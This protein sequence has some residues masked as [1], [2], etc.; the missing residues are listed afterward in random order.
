MATS[1]NF[2][3]GNEWDNFDFDEKEEEQFD[4]KEAEQDSGFDELM[5]DVQKSILEESKNVNT[6]KNTKWAMNTF[7]KWFESYPKSS[8]IP[9]DIIKLE[10]KDLNHC[11][12]LFFMQV[13]KHDKTR[14]PRQ[15][16]FNIACGI[17]RFFKIHGIMDR[18][19][20]DKDQQDFKLAYAA[21]DASMKASTSVG[22]GL[23]K[24]QAEPITVDQET[25]LW[26]KG[27]FGIHSSESLITALY[28]YN[29]KLFGLRSRDEHRNLEI[30]DFQMGQDFT[31][32]FIIYSGRVTKT[33]KGGI[34]DKKI[35]P[36]VVKHYC[37]E[38]EHERNPFV[39]YG[40]YF[41]IVSDGAFYRK[42]LD[43]MKFSKQV[44]GIHTISNYLPKAMKSCGF[45]G[46]YTGHSGKVTCATT[47]FN[48]S[49]PEK[50]IKERTGHRS[51]AVRLYERT[52]DEQLK[53]VSTILNPPAAKVSKLEEK[54]ETN[55]NEIERNVVKNIVFKNC[56]FNNVT[57]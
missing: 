23:R 52:S 25:V 44:I 7:N 56:T 22:I 15:T 39:F 46:Y 3:L 24:K 45:E 27:K 20:L 13:R 29:S 31:G 14:Y 34:T 40:K 18:N 10:K 33:F 32:K 55:N 12:S 1:V 49:I 42:P 21:L 2:D 26:E 9:D 43:G 28:Y 11:L 38:E 30:K 6:D 5:I 53:R 35:D 8:K 19:F 57:F 47:L 54:H 36:K 4:S 50:L 48:S 16:L 41:E 51:D 17:C 37:P